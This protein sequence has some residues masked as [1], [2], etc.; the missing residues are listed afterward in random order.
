[1]PISSAPRTLSCL[2]LATGTFAAVALMPPAQAA[3]AA[4]APAQPPLQ[5]DGLALLRKWVPPVYPP[6]LLKERKGGMVTVRLVVSN[7]GQVTSA[8]ALEDSDP[9]F[10]ESA[11]NA[12]NAWEFAPAVENGHAAACC[13]DT[14]VTYSPDEGQRKASAIPPQDIR[15]S[16]PPRTAPEPKTTPPGEYPAILSERKFGGRVK[17]ACQINPEGRALNP[18]ITIASHVDFVLPALQALKLWE[19]T[20]ALQGDLAVAAPVTGVV[21]FD[22][23]DAQ[24]AEVLA[25]NG[26]TAVDGS[27]VPNAPEMLGVADPVWP[28]DALLKR[29]A[30]AATVEFT[31]T[32]T[33]MVEELKLIDATAPEFGQSLLAAMQAWLFN[34]AIENNRAVSVRLRRHVEFKP[35]PADAADPADA[36]VRVLAA[37]QQNAV[38]SAKGLDVRLAPLY[39]VAPEYPASLK[40]GTS[41]APAGRAE[42]EIVID[43]DGRVRLPRIISAT[44]PEFGWAAATAAAQW[45][46]A[47]PRRGGAP[48]DVKARVPFDFAAPKD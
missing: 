15:F 28:L 9:A 29:E 13:L 31:V 2:L 43:R 38:G 6:T 19:F 1:M 39:R 44:Q 20:P 17:F 22:P 4:A 35:P 12:V 14:L 45:V 40:G 27:P 36:N 46:F 24:L 7:S 16:V 37:V 41:P 47:P 33:G 48:V 30:G 10:V 3:P 42:L 18:R 32:E 21:T 5:A 8:R 34:P 11:V 25:L 26:I 23:L